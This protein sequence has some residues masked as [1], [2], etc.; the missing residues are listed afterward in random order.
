MAD[1][2][3]E[4]K[5]SSRED[6]QLNIKRNDRVRVI[7]DNALYGMLDTAKI[8]PYVSGNA[9]RFVLEDFLKLKDAVREYLK[10]VP[11]DDEASKQLRILTWEKNS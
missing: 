7:S 11:E 3:E 9:V 5:K 6:L 1:S 2:L 4:L 10:T 8:S